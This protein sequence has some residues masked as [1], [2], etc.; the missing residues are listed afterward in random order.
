MY[1]APTNLTSSQYFNSILVSP[2]K[3]QALIINRPVIASP[4]DCVTAEMKI[5]SKCLF[6]CP[7]GYQLQGPSFTRCGS[8]GQWTE[9]ANVSCTGE[10]FLKI[11]F[12][13]VTFSHEKVRIGL[14]LWPIKTS[15]SL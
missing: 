6:T 10:F 7:Q 1:T 2:G 11:K 15:F 14:S 13:N 5:N 8:S 12:S 3:C 4:N 9:S